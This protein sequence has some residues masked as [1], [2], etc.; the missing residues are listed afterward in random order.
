MNAASTIPA[1]RRAGRRREHWQGR[2][3]RRPRLAERLMILLALCLVVSAP[4]AGAVSYTVLAPRLAAPAEPVPTPVLDEFLRTKVANI[5]FAPYQGETCREVQFKNDT[6]K[7][8]NERSVNCYSLMLAELALAG[9]Q[10]D[11]GSRLHQIRGFFGN[12]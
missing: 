3:A 11:G 7:F 1:D 6:G 9:N 8:A 5:L 10:P 2:R 4:L 12:K